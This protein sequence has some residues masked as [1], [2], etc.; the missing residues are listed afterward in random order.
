MEQRICDIISQMTLEEKAG[1]CSGQDNWH[2]KAV[3]RLGIPAVMVSDGPHGLRKQEEKGD[4]L[5]INESIKAVCFPAACATASSFDRKLVQ[6]MGEAL[7][8]ECRAEDVSILLG[9]AINIKRSPLCG[10]NFEYFSEDPYLAGKMAAAEIQ[11]IQSWSVG[12]S[13][14]HFAANN[15][16]FRR[17]SCSSNMRERTL[18]EIYLAGFE[19]AV[20]EAKPWTLMCSYNRINGEFASENKALLTDILRNEWGFEG[21]VMS[22]WGAVNDRVKGLQAGLELEMPGNGGLN[23]KK[24]MEAVRNG[25]LDEAVLD[26]AVE[27]ILKTVLRYRDAQCPAAKFD[28]E[29]HH[30]KAAKLETECAVLLKNNGVLPLSKKARIAYIGGFAATPRYQG[31]GSSHINASRVCSALSLAPEQV[32]YAQGFSAK[33]DEYNEEAFGEAIAA[34][35]AA[36]AAVIFAGLPDSFESEGYDRTHMRMPDCQNELIRRI[37]AVQK[38]TVVVLHNGSPVEL[39]W[40]EDVSAILEMYLGGEGIGEATHALLYG[41]ANPSG[42][43]AETFPM[44]LAHNPSALNFPGDGKNVN[45]AE[46]VF[47]GYRYY[48][49]KELPVRYP[50]GHGLSYTSFA[51]GNLRLNTSVLEEG[52]SIVASVDVTNTGSRPGKEVVQFYVADQTGTPG[53]PVRELKGFEKVMLQPGETKTVTTTLDSRSVQWYH[54][55]LGCWYAA[56]GTYAVQVCRNAD[57]VELSAPLEYRSRTLLSFCVDAN[58]TVAELLADSRTEA[59]AREM[60]RRAMQ[61]LG[62]GEQTKADEDTAISSEMVHQM[63]INIPL[64]GICA[65]GHKGDDALNA[66]IDGYNRLLQP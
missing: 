57:A 22:D 10:R 60:L 31:G 49:A 1:L 19:I 39:P 3:E 4:H 38:N 9:P 62:A 36:E 66:M 27:R 46:G 51:Y 18:R 58:T 32:V 61:A 26:K 54:E 21:C 50:F 48:T 13:L 44:K 43:L 5:G 53:R 15:Q 8:V 28:R 12:T 11:G 63:A 25:T 7:G 55:G 30:L 29:A 59:A 37:A 17:M 41:D 64:R 33:E 42:R 6:E 23:D 35:K 40:A 56:S 45:Y 47:V 34:A 16:E 24:I 2:L 14:K 52:G 65:F 20:K